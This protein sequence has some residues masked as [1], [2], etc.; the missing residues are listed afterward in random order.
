MSSTTNN[1]SKRP[2]VWLAR[3]AGQSALAA[4]IAAAGFEVLNFSPL[5]L[6]AYLPER[7]KA[8]LKLAE[9]ADLAVFVSPSA[10]EI[11]QQRYSQSLKKNCPC[12]GPG[13]GTAVALRAAGFSSI[14]YP[15]NEYSSEALLALPSLNSVVG[16]CVWLI[17]G[18]TGRPLIEATLKAR[19]ARVEV[20]RCYQRKPIDDWSALEQKE[21]DYAVFS[22]A[23]AYTAA[24]DA[25]PLTVAAARLIV[26]SERLEKL[27]SPKRQN[28]IVV[29]NGLGVED[30]TNALLA[31]EENTG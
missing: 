17:A 7:V 29:C 4:S 22:S 6:S 25:L 11:F 8:R 9:A 20:V 24:A 15:K 19:G 16:K 26:S 2:T 3:N 18:D 30:V 27:L 14:E 31:A 5:A 1:T 10:V 23:Q 21:I 12:F 28:K 13:K